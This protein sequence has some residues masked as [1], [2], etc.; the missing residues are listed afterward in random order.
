MLKQGGIG[1]WEEK[2]WLYFELL[3]QWNGNSWLVGSHSQ[4]SS[5][6]SLQRVN[7][8]WWE[9]AHQFLNESQGL[10]Q[11]NMTWAAA[12][13]NLENI[14]DQNITPFGTPELAMMWWQIAVFERF[15]KTVMLHHLFAFFLVY[16]RETFFG[17]SGFI[18]IPILH[19]TQFY[20]KNKA[21][22]NTQC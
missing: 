15:Y 4:Q 21:K 5:C 16:F 13:S 10:F 20:N 22:A 9:T 11:G 14:F 7:K 8:Q 6:A 18:R 17:V 3:F 1:W 12:L 19:C 2:G